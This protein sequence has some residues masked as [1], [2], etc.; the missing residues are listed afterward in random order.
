VKTRA[1]KAARPVFV[2][3][4]G[5]SGSGKTWL[6]QRLQ[7]RLGRMA[8]RLSLDDFYKDRSHLS[9]QRRAKLNFD[10]PAAID[11]KAFHEALGNLFHRRSTRVPSYDFRTH[12]R[13]A[14]FKIVNPKAIVLVDGLWL[15]RR[16]AIRRFLDLR[17][18]LECA[19]PV[20]LRRRLKRDLASRGRT[21]ASV[22]NQFKKIV[23]PMHRRYVA[24]QIHWADIVVKG[25]CG[26]GQARLLAESIRR[27]KD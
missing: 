13:T 25:N 27:L 24:P 22:L 19:A 2:G 26:R 8:A 11:W 16:P 17:I 9:P 1:E 5:G 12:A 15:L 6:A 3:I 20:R 14:H 23:E 10:H 7:A 18:F 21:R 4:V